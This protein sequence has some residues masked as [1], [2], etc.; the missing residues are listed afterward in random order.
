MTSSDVLSEATRWLVELETSDRI[1]DIWSEFDDW[2]EASAKHRTAYARARLAWLKS[3]GLRAPPTSQV[4]S[5][6]DGHCAEGNRLP[7][8]DDWLLHWFLALAA[9]VVLLVV[10]GTEVR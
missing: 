6:E 9:L 8:A 10:G 3:A 2:F 5:R 7:C 1:E 4:A